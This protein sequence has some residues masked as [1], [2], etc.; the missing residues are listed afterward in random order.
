MSRPPLRLA[1][2]AY[3]RRGEETLMMRR[4]KRP[5]D[6]HFGKWNG[7]GGKFEPG[8]SPE[9]C[10]RR[11]VFEESGLEV[12]RAELKGVLTWPAFDGTHHWY[13]FAYVVTETRG[14]VDVDPPE[15]TLR[16]VPTRDLPTLEL[17]EGDRVFLPWLDRPGFFSATFRYDAGRLVDHEVAFYPSADAS[18]E[19]PTG[20][21]PAS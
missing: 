15:G 20:G 17:W 13:A 4:D 7:L 2:L 3:V 8:E 6:Q 16:W 18:A 12:V 1:T 19:A 9:A 14:E 11:E 5:D 21:E 10:L